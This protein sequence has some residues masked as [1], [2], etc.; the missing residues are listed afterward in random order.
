SDNQPLLALHQR[1]FG[2]L[3]DRDEFF[4]G[5]GANVDK[6]AQAI[7]LA[8][9]A[10][11]G[12]IANG[13]VF[14]STDCVESDERGLQAVLPQAEC[15]FSGTYRAG[16]SAVLVHD[17]FG[18]LSRRPEAVADEIDFRF[19][20]GKVVLRSALQDKTRAQRGEIRNARDVKEYVL[21]QHRGKSRE[22]FLRLP[23]LALEVDDI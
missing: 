1:D 12:F 20:N 2:D 19:H 14:D 3:L 8:E 16:L 9:I 17:N 13:A 11:R 15:F 18:V 6:C 5:L 10:A 21:R 4:R 23:A 7:V 22:N